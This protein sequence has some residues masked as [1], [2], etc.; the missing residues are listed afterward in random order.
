[1]F[2]ERTTASV[3]LPGGHDQRWR[4][5]SVITP[6]HS[7]GRQVYIPWHEADDVGDGQFSVLT[8]TVYPRVLAGIGL[9]DPSGELHYD[10]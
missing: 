4:N 6:R 2:D 7:R 1:M 9:P 3:V 8:L 5:C 10:Q